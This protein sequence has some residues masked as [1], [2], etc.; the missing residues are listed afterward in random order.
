M[1][2]FHQPLS[3]IYKKCPRTSLRNVRLGFRHLEGVVLL[4]I[5]VLMSIGWSYHGHNRPWQL[6]VAVAVF[7]AFCFVTE[8]LLWVSNKIW[9]VLDSRREIASVHKRRGVNPSDCTPKS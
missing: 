4:G 5:A 8:L 2:K 3:S 6:D 9:N 7:L 1:S